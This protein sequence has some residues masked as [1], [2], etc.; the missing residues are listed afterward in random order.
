MT[1]L[2]RLYPRAW[3]DRYEDEFLA[4]L[5]SRPPDVLDR[6]DI[7]RGAVDARLHPQRRADG[8]P[9][10]TDGGGVRISD[11]L[12]AAGVFLGAGLLLAGIVAAVNGPMV[13]D[14]HGT[15]R[16]GAA[17]LP[18]FVAALVLL[19]AGAIRTTRRLPSSADGTRGGAAMLAVFG[20]AT[21]PAGPGG[22]RVT[23][24]VRRSGV[25]A[26]VS[27]IVAMALVGACGGAAEPGTPAGTPVQVVGGQMTVTA[28]AIAFVPATTTTAPTDLTI[29]F[30]NKD[31]GIPHDLVLYAG[32]VKL[33]ATE[34]VTGPATTTLS[35]PKLVPGDYRFTCTVHPNMQASLLVTGS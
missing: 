28:E 19:A 23:R 12:V 1:A 24:G 35:D 30:E 18:F 10:P 29:A 4:L 16:D 27:V 6:V 14:E 7:V 26:V 20:P 25:A 2:L 33:A 3:R 11:R 9:D 8:A 22:V 21:D 34:I 15:Y 31:A 13:T 5:E 17:A 32:D